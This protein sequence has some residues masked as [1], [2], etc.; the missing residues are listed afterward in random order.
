MK[1]LNKMDASKW[2]TVAQVGARNPHRDR[3]TELRIYF[4]PDLPQPFV[5]ETL[6]QTVVPGEELRIR[7]QPSDTLTEAFKAFEAGSNLTEELRPL[8]QRWQVRNEK[9][10]AQYSIDRSAKRGFNGQTFAETLDWLY[11]DLTKYPQRH[12][13]LAM[14]KDFGIP[15]R[16]GQQLAK[17]ERDGKGRNAYI[18]AFIKALR[19]FDRD[20]WNASREAL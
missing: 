15:L 6:G 9:R 19:W 10:V 3:W 4:T 1:N 13:L 16:T 12:A 5:S 8:A 14:E 17:D 20:A 2:E 11:P 7:R 18:T